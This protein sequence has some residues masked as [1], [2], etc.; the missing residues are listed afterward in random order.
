MKYSDYFLIINALTT[1]IGTIIQYFIGQNPEIFE[2]VDGFIDY[3]SKRPHF[4]A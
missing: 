2:N 1:G 4:F 3:K